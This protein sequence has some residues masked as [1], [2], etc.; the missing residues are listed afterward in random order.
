MSDLLRFNLHGVLSV[1]SGL[2][3]L[4]LGL[5]VFLKDRS[6]GV[7]RAFFYFTL[8]ATIWIVSYGMISLLKH[9]PV[10]NFFTISA[11]FYGIAFIPINSYLFSVRFRGRNENTIALWLGYAWA[12]SLFFLAS[13]SR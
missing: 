8:S 5:M 10:G 6:S 13:V 2:L 7:N 1:L 4:A 9:A 11:Y 12:A 3:C